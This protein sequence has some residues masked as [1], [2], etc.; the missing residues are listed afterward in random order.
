MN[1]VQK[2]NMLYRK[3][4]EKNIFI[5]LLQL[6]GVKYTKIFS[7]NYYEKHRNYSGPPH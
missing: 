3:R 6:L 4:Q 5:C 2:M 7:L 1:F